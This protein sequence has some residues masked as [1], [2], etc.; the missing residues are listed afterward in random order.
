LTE[1][2]LVHGRVGAAR[3]VSVG[4]QELARKRLGR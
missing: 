4:A 2:R 3:Y 1:R